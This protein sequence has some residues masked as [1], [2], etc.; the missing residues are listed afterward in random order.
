MTKYP[1]YRY[2][3][4]RTPS[5]RFSVAIDSAG[6]VAAAVFGG[7]AVLRRRLKGGALKADPSR[8]AEARRQVGAWLRGAMRAFSL[9][10]APAGTPFQLRVWTALRRIP[11][12]QTRS[13]GDVARAVRSSPRAVGRA[14]ASN[15][16]CL[17]IPCHRVVG[18]DGSLTGYAFGVGRKRRLL[19]LEAA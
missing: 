3:S 17:M 2:S 16:V 7:K 10:L 9:R 11:Y 1:I 19:G 12:G 15:P 5:G 14:S 4:F 18:R 13:Y 6:S 8:T